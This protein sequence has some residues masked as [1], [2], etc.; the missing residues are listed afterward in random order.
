ACLHGGGWGRGDFGATVIGRLRRGWYLQR[1]SA[2]LEDVAA[3]TARGQA[4]R[5][6]NVETVP[7]HHAEELRRG[8]TDDLYREIV[9]NQLDAF[10]GIAAS[11]FSLPIGIA[12]HSV[13]HGAGPFISRH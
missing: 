8:H 13:R 12:G 2:Q 11:E 6:P 5:K 9:D 7:N 1:G 10:R 3:H 4:K